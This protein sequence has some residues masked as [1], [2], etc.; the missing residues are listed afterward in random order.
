MPG[1]PLDI[2]YLAPD[3]LADMPH[4]HARVLVT[5]NGDPTLR[6][7]L[8]LPK[9]FAHAGQMGPV[10]DGLFVNRGLC[11]FT[12]SDEPGAPMI[13]VTVTTLPFE[14]P[15]DEWTRIAMNADRWSVVSGRWFPGPNS[16]FYDLTGVRTVDDVELVRR[17][18]ARLDGNRLV[19]VN[20]MCARTYW[21]QNKQDFWTAHVTFAL[22]GGLD[23]TQIEPWLQAATTAPDFETAYPRSWSHEAAESAPDTMS[24]LHFR[25]TDVE[26]TRLLAYLLVR[27]QRKQTP[28]Q[29]TLPW[30]LSDTLAMLEKSGLVL[31]AEPQPIAEEADPRSLGV[32]GWLGGFQGQGRVG[33]AELTVRLGFIARADVVFE[34]ALYSPRREDDLITALRAQR[35]FE[36]VRAELTLR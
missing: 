3:T 34:L 5:P 19:F 36:I 8:A 11:L 32:E 24:A 13:A 23:S 18:S 26:Q 29:A 15:A 31:A 14:L 12:N 33:E 17:T 22:L 7:D 30:L 16:L 27:A 4:T 9:D 21:D 2:P 28:E 20:T 10:P 25:L 35:A 1:A 6:F